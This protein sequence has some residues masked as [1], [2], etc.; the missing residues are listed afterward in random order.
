MRPFRLDRHLSPSPRQERG[1]DIGGPQER[2]LVVRDNL[3]RRLPHPLQG[4]LVS[5]QFSQAP[6]E[7]LFVLHD[8][9]SLGIR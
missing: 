4:I 5:K 3:L 8:Q 6:S 9:S 1:N 7:V 2:A